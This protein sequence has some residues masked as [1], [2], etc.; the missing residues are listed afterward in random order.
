[1]FIGV[2]TAQVGAA[3]EVGLK[4]YVLVPGNAVE[5]VA[6]IQVP[7]MLF[8]DVDCNVPG[9]WFWQYCPSWLN[10]GIVGEFIVI[11][12]WVLVAHVGKTEA[13]GVNV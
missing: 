1:M 5:I 8:D 9:T 3:V 7:E 6:G 4:V 11:L 12:I 10:V 13:V 2:L